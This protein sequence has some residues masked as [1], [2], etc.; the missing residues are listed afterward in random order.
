[1]GEARQRMAAVVAAGASYWAGEAEVVQTYFRRPRTRAQDLS[2]LKAQAYKEARPFRELPRDLQEEFLRTGTLR[3]H[4]EGVEAARRMAQETG[5]F[6]LLAD[7]IAE[8]FGVTV[9]PTDVLMLPADRKLQELRAAY[10]AGGGGVERAA[11][12]FTEGGGGAMFQILS[13]L[14]GGGLE[15]KIASVFRVI[16]DEEIPHG[17]MAIYTVADRAQ[18]EA[19]WQRARTIVRSISR[20]RLLM[21]NEMF[22]HPLSVARIREIDE[23]RI[24]PWKMP[25]PV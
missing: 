18:H 21:R 6:W 15:R 22:G 13:Q 10:R 12:G 8:F 1:M 16:A 19:D 2:W 7:L 25:V 14:D 9:A 20:Q 17:P 24:E 11:V 4:P 3:D 5:H 23:G